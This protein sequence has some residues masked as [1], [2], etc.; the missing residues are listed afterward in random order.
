MKRPLMV[1]ALTAVAVLVAP[2]AGS[3]ATADPSGGSQKSQVQ[4][5]RK[6]AKSGELE[7]QVESLAKYVSGEP[8]SQSLD[9]SKARASG[10]S[11]IVVKV[12]QE[13]VAANNHLVD[14]IMSGTKLDDVSLDAFPLVEEMMEASPSQGEVVRNGQIPLA[15]AGVNACGDKKHPVPSKSPTR[16]KKK[17]SNPHSALKKAGFHK[18]AGYA[19]GA[20]G[21]TCANDY[22]QGRGMSTKYGYCKSPRFRNQG[23]VTGKK[24][25]WIQYGEPNP[26]IHKYTWPYLTWGAYVKWWH[27]K[28]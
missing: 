12:T 9:A 2:V 5:V 21:Y 13:T 18:T 10:S 14:E 20:R 24:S 27:D 25:Y 17:S 8:G 1:V 28:H 3:A 15:K 26:E 11:E 7:A 4:T 19:C 22:T 23:Y 16:H 6:L